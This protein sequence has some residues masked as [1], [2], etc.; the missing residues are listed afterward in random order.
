MKSS[1][2]F[3]QYADFKSA[4]T[5]QHKYNPFAFTFTTSKK[6]RFIE[7]TG[8]ELRVVKPEQGKEYLKCTYIVYFRSHDGYCSETEDPEDAG[9]ELETQKL[10][11]LYFTIPSDLT[12]SEG[13]FNLELLDGEANLI[14]SDDTAHYFKTWTTESACC[15]VC[16]YTNLYWPQFVEWVKIV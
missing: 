5:I 8:E 12:D 1:N 7:S 16:G 2:P 9:Y 11:V 3:A 14:N 4:N 13:K 6:I 10:V 15:G